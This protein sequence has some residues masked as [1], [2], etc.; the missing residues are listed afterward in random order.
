M[1]P[2][3]SNV[4]EEVNNSPMFEETKI[5]LEKVP[6]KSANDKEHEKRAKKSTEKD[7]INDQNEDV[8]IVNPTSEDAIVEETKIDKEMTA[9]GSQEDIKDVNES[10]DRI[11]A[12]QRRE[13][14]SIEEKGAEVE[15]SK[16]ESDNKDSGSSIEEKVVN[17]KAECDNKDSESLTSKDTE[18]EGTKNKEK[19]LE[20]KSESSNDNAT[21]SETAISHDKSET[22]D[23]KG[24]IM[25]D[26]AQVITNAGA[27]S[28]PSIEE[29]TGDT[30]RSEV[31]ST[32]KQVE[33]VI[34]KDVLEEH[35]ER[36][37]ELLE[38]DA[39]VKREVSDSEKV[40]NEKNVS[41][42]LDNHSTDATNATDVNSDNYTL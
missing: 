36:G 31:I 2:T 1:K 38:V 27:I 20:G 42:T 18:V 14:S 22:I 19:E 9:N 25:D 10:D 37:E 4:S 12:D 26:P 28:S 33:P 23:N 29:E 35:E 5:D 40:P 16:A 8:V 3:D 7:K 21:N 15:N 30:S 32:M 17:S 6:D 39:A 13:G 41:G 11:A 24:E 34:Q